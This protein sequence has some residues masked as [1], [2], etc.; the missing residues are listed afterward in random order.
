M[1]LANANLTRAEKIQKALDNIANKKQRFYFFVPET[2]G[3]A[4]GAVI[5]IYNQI[6]VLRKAGYDASPI[7]E[8]RDYEVPAYLDEEA[9][10]LKHYHAEKS[11][12]PV[13]PEDILVIP[14]F[15]TPL[16]E[17]TKNMG[18]MRI[19][20]AQTYDY[21]IT[22]NLP[23]MIW[24]NYGMENVISTSTSLSTFIRKYHGDFN[25]DIKEYKIGVP[26]YFGTDVL[27]KPIITFYTRNPQDIAKVSKLFYYLYPEFQWVV[28]DDLRG[29]SR[30]DFARK[31]AE[32]PVMVWIDRMA[33]FGQTPL[34]AMKAGT[35]PV[36]LAPDQIPEY[37]VENTGAWTS[38]FYEI[39]ELLGKVLKMWIND[40][41]PTELVEG[42]KAKAAEHTQAIS[43]ASI[44]ET[45]GYFIKKREVEL[46]EILTAITAPKEAPAAEETTSEQE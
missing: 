25:Y 22:S 43:D 38:S 36:G 40:N 30:A 26:E 41:M 45:F 5:E 46:T 31:M 16:M 39:P 1:Q 34:E 8:R 2:N 20:L 23:G 37:M 29:S 18:C 12:F 9:R 15:F 14:E 28:F 33:G 27:K 19:V 24:K 32:S 13:S 42:M 17:Q 11:T 6:S 10:A 7:S 44:L 21:T 4:S 3:I 35:V